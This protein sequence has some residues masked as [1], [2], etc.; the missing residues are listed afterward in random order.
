MKKEFNFEQ[1]GKKMPYSVP[2]G[3]FDK[4]ESEVMESI[5]TSTPSKKDGSRKWKFGSAIFLAIAASVALLLI[6]KPRMSEK[7]SQPYDFEN[8]QLAYNNLSTEDQ[9][10]LIEIYQ[11]EETLSTEENYY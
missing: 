3:F 10:F 2:D 8:V 11:E 7:Q 4:L 1:I 9:Q 5:I 6:V